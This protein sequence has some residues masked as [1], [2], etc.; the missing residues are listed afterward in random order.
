MTIHFTSDTHFGHKNIIGFQ[1]EA[2]GMFASVAEMDATMIANWN[3]VVGKGDVVYHLGD[4][5]FAPQGRIREVLNQLNGHIR[6]L[7]GNHDRAF[8]KPFGEVMILEGYLE[9]MYKGYHEIRSNGQLIVLNHYSQR[10]WRNSHH[11]AIH[12]YGHSHG[13]L[14]GV[15]KSV[16]VGVD[17][18]EMMQFT[19]DYM[20]PYSL[21]E[22]L[23]YM[24][25]KVPY[26]PDHHNENTGK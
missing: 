6:L 9:T 26:M 21:D 7:V 10:V 24:D 23:A 11:G 17:S 22:I 12:L 25:K 1:T 3:G 5:A 2:R 13:T 15:G 8:N 19:G 14:P 18:E 16:D 20:R 4:F